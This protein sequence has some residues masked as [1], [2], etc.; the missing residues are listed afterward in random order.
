MLIFGS[1]S[2]VLRDHEKLDVK[3]RTPTCKVSVPAL[4][5]VNLPP[6]FM[7][8]CE[9]QNNLTFYDVVYI[10]I[11]CA[12]PITWVLLHPTMSELLKV[13]M[14][15]LLDFCLGFCCRIGGISMPAYANTSILWHPISSGTDR[16]RKWLF[17]IG[18]CIYEWF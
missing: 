12:Y 5:A 10:I 15:S 4:W 13:I 3:F 7:L 11:M 18:R 2:T 17:E 9:P 1:H 16:T 8:I 6:L 14:S